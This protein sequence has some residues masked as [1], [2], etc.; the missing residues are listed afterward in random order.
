MAAAAEVGASAS[1]PRGG[2]GVGSS[3]PE[4]ASALAALEV[5]GRQLCTAWSFRAS[6]A[7]SGLGSAGVVRLPSCR[8]RLGL[9]ALRRGLRL[10]R[11]PGELSP[12]GSGPLSDAPSDAPPAVALPREMPPS[13]ELAWGPRSPGRSG[14]LGLESG[15]S[16]VGGGS[17]S[18]TFQVTG[19]HILVEFV[20]RH[21]TDFEDMVSDT[22]FSTFPGMVGC[23][24]GRSGSARTRRRPPRRTRVQL[25]GRTV[26]G[27]SEFDFVPAKNPERR[28]NSTMRK[29][30]RVC[31][32]N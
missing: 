5:L 32:L 19:F 21:L 20:P 6:G 1:A 18:H 29:K 13:L 28:G 11:A 7:G 15:R 3:A 10:P 27:E 22:V 25:A 24:R 17:A 12:Q 2:C 16:V 30:R 31:H 14:G 23:E 26:T 9:A 8:P 4:L